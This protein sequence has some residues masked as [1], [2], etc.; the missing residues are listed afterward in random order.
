MTGQPWNSTDPWEQRSS[1]VVHFWRGARQRVRD[2]RVPASG[3][4]SPA[5]LVRSVILAFVVGLILGVPLWLAWTTL[6]I[7]PGHPAQ[8]AGLVTVHAAGAIDRSAISVTDGDTIRVRGRPTRLV[9]FNAPESYEPRCAN[10]R[11]LGERAKARL[12]QIVGEGN[13]TFVRIACSC[14]PGTEGTQV[15]NFGRACGSLSSNGTDIGDILI[16]EGLA[17]PFHCGQT[18]CPT[19]P[20]P[21]C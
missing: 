19:L 5:I 2:V 14:P 9:G 6:A 21:W 18:S 4:Q 16:S 7:P 12:K 8:A 11:T 15:C 3:R 17:V 1:R 13:L 10:E 20:R